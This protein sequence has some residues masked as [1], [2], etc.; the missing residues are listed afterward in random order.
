MVF[1]DFAVFEDV[2][3]VAVTVFAG[4]SFFGSVFETAVVFATVFGFDSVLACGADG[5]SDF[6]LLL[7]SFIWSAV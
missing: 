3:A 6:S 7:F 5:F 1:A 4:V 2:F